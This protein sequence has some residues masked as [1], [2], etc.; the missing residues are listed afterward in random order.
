MTKLI[1]DIEVAFSADE[2]CGFIAEPFT[3]EM[4]R[5]IDITKQS[6]MNRARSTANRRKALE[7][8]LKQIGMT[9]VEFDELERLARRPFIL[10]TDGHIL[11]T[12]TNVQGFLV[13][14]TDELRSASKPCPKEQVRSRIG[15]TPWAT[16]K[17]AP[18][19]VYERFATV[20]GGA[21]N[22][23]SNQRA[24][25]SSHYISGFSAHGQMSIDPEFVKPSVLEGAIRWGGE[26][27]GIG[28]ARKMGWGR[29][30]L[31]SFEE[32]HLRIAAE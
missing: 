14:T 19:G 5:Y 15:I 20:T 22:K 26:N 31:A 3:P 16:A 12:K 1:F 10:D 7:E 17:K 27:V 25:R 18:D 24:L 13:A 32:Q 11:I 8:H 2:G 4:S 29:F 30:T 9:L 6:G 28:A 23:L 21:G